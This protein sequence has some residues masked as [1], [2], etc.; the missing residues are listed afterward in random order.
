M[1]EK[2]ERHSLLLRP[3]LSNPA[4]KEELNS[5]NEKEKIRY[6][7]SIDVIMINFVNIKRIF[8]FFYLEHRKNKR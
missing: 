6:K 1:E 5:L 4:C 2:K 8:N 3:N 7:E